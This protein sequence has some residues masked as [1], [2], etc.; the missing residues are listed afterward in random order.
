MSVTLREGMSFSQQRG[1]SLSSCT[2]S[3]LHGA[4]H[5]SSSTRIASALRSRFHLA[6]GLA[7]EGE[8]VYHALHD[9][10]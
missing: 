4:F 2:G 1:T 5:R 8:Q 10:P 3:A 9:V 7:P 6:F